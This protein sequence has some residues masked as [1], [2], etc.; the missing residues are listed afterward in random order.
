MYNPTAGAGDTRPDGKLAQAGGRQ[1]G[2][3]PATHMAPSGPVSRI[4]GITREQINH[5]NALNGSAGTYYP[6][7][8]SYPHPA[9]SRPVP[10]SL[11]NR[12]PDTT[13]VRQLYEGL[14]GTHH[15]TTFAPRR[16]PDCQDIAAHIATCEICQKY[17][18]GDN[19][20]LQIAFA[21]VSVIA[22]IAVLQ[23]CKPRH[24]NSNSKDV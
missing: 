7:A 1:L 14:D 4:S 13:P 8:P 19:V 12:P 24:S 21:A 15:Q 11:N 3:Q 23:A 10:K 2:F 22:V 18:K 16:A 5:T 6:N 17:H 9:I 20:A